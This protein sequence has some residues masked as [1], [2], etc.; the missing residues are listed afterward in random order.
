MTHK[1]AAGC[2]LRSCK[3][4]FFPTCNREKS[5]YKSVQHVIQIYSASFPGSIIKIKRIYVYISHTLTTF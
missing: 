5:V 1:Q 2:A 4:Y 3:K